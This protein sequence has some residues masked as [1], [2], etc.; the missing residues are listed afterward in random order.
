[1]QPGDLMMLG[2]NAILYDPVRLHG[3]DEGPNFGNVGDPVT[4][5]SAPDAQGFARVIH[6]AYGI[7]D[8]FSHSLFPMTG[9]SNEAR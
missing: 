9:E 2:G 8:V 4:I 7:Q 1:M 3:P 5:I 6:P